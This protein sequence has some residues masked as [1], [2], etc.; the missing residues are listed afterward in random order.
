MNGAD[1]IAGILQKE[2]VQFIPAFP[3]SDLIDSG[4]KL[5]IRPLIVRQERHALHI[6]DGYARMTGGR[7]IC[8]TTVQYGPGSENAIGAVAQ[9]YADNVPVLH[10]P[11]GYKR[12]DQ[13]SKPNYAPHATC[14]SSTSGV[15]WSIQADRIP[16]MMQKRFRDAQKRPP[17]SCDAGSADRHFTERGRS[18]VAR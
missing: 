16:R 10:M 7:K 2:G 4:A 14:N 6:A 5:G 17:R 15:R 18:R 9:C 13:G 3:H 8:C 12:A 11:G 1:L